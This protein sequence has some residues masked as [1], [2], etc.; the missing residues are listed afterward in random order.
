M[1]LFLPCHTPKVDKVWSKNEPY[2]NANFRKFSKMSMLF[3]RLSRW[4]SKLNGDIMTHKSMEI[5]FSKQHFVKEWHCPFSLCHILSYFWSSLSHLA[6]PGYIDGINRSIIHFKI[7][8]KY[9]V[10]CVLMLNNHFVMYYLFTLETRS[11][12]IHFHWHTLLFVDTIFPL[13]LSLRIMST[14]FHWV[15]KVDKLIHYKK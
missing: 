2:L 12:I 1:S 10:C 4:T 5:R 14:F 13:S 7:F 9:L 6:A 8:M 11:L 15:D 3:T